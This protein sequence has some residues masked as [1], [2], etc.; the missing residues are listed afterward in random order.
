[1]SSNHRMVT[2]AARKSA[3]KKKNVRHM[4]IERADNGFTAET[5]FNPEGEGEKSQYVDPERKVFN[6]H[7]DL[8]DHVMS[9]FG[10]V[11]P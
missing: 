9:T 7:K 4:H 8:A 6:S 11:R 10:G 3:P 2:S 5:H 1:M